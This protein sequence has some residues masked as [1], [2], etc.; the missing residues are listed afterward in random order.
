[1][2]K[3]I[4]ILLCFSLCLFTGC[5]K[6]KTEKVDLVVTEDLREYVEENAKPNPVIEEKETK[7]YNAIYKNYFKSENI[8]PEKCM[9]NLEIVNK[10]KIYY[11]HTLEFNDVNYLYIEDVNNKESIEIFNS[12]DRT[13]FN[14]DL[15][16]NTDMFYITEE[17]ERSL[18]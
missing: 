18:K 2:N 10:D 13:Y 11:I 9:I 16:N 14:V 1:M 12:I 15:K 17:Y 6:A 7:D 4:L 5:N 8:Y 3:K